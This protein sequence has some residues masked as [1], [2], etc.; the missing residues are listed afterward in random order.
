MLWQTSLVMEKQRHLHQIFVTVANYIT[1]NIFVKIWYVFSVIA[2]FRATKLYQGLIFIGIWHTKL[3]LIVNK[4]VIQHPNKDAAAKM[5]QYYKQNDSIN[6]ICTMCLKW[7]LAV[8]TPRYI[9]FILKENWSGPTWSWMGN[10][11]YMGR[12]VNVWNFMEKNFFLQN[13]NTFF[14]FE[15][16][17][18]VIFGFFTSKLLKLQILL[19]IQ[20]TK[21]KIWT[22]MHYHK[23]SRLPPR[24]QKRGIV[25]QTFDCNIS[26]TIWDRSLKFGSFSYPHSIF[27]CSKFH[28]NL[29]RWVSCMAHYDVEFHYD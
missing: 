17:L 20:W 9:A 21:L 14:S 19:K 10:W 25:V 5:V 2:I 24:G 12:W 8:I 6:N 22:N 16:D 18:R 3:N 4:V 28:W 13:F 7:F 23:F 1:C 11:Y 29:K 27:M 26:E 15:I